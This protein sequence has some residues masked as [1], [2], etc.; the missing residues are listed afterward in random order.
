MQILIASTPLFKSHIVQIKQ[1][2]LMPIEI[3]FK[4]FKSHIVQIKPTPPVKRIQLLKYLN[5]T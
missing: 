4:K 5:P 1:I 2:K 3:T